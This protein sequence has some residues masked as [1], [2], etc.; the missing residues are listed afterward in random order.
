M[1]EDGV[2]LEQMTYPVSDCAVVLIGYQI[3]LL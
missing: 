3:A 2:L 1:I